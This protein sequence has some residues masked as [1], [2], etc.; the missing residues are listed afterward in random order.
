MQ[1]SKN[2]VID[3]ICIANQ[4]KRI[5]TFG[6]RAADYRHLLHIL[7]FRFRCV[8]PQGG[9]QKCADLQ[10]AAHQPVCSNFPWFWLAIFV[11]ISWHL[12]L[13]EPNQIQ[14]KFNEIRLFSKI[15]LSLIFLLSF[16][17][18]LKIRINHSKKLQQK[19]KCSI[20]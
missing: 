19:K 1:T 13:S 20:M 9:Q 6:H 15:V 12:R 16:F 17:C 7:V 8:T 10:R 3:T 18:F 11:P 14:T 4:S 5:P 2:G